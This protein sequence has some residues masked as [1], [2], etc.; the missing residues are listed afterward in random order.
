MLEPAVEPRDVT[1]LVTEVW[2]MVRGRVVWRSSCGRPLAPT[3]TGGELG[4]TE[5][6]ASRINREM[7]GWRTEGLRL[8]V[9]GSLMSKG[10]RREGESSVTR[11]SDDGGTAV[12]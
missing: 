11:A 1:E 6:E 2:D 4:N 10:E 3:M 12:W 9:R 7:A 8:D 5:L